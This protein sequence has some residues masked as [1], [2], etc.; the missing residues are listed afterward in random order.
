MGRWR[1]RLLPTQPSRLPS[2]SFA[3]PRETKVVEGYERRLLSRQYNSVCT[4]PYADINQRTL[5]VDPIAVRSDVDVLAANAR[6]AFCLSTEEFGDVLFV[7]IGAA[8]V[9]TVKLAEKITSIPASDKID[10]S[11]KTEIIIEKGEEVGFFE[12]GGSSIVVAFE[13]GRIIFDQDL[14][15]ASSDAIETDVEMGMSLGRATKVR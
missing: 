2:V 1:S 5:Q 14:K 12:F 4:L 11:A 3:G 8:E 9:G 6:S 7:A 15:D 13:P 10:P